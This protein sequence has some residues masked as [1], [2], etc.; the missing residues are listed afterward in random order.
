MAKTAEI[1]SSI[2]RPRIA[3]QWLRHYRR[4]FE[5]RDNLLGRSAY[6]LEAPSNAKLDDLS[7]AGA[8]ES[9]RAISLLSAGATK[10]RISD[11]LEA[12]LRIERGGYGICELTGEEIETERLQA[13][14]WTR[15]SLKGQMQMEHAGLGSR[16]MLTPVE[17][18]ADSESPDDQDSD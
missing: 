11:V 8:E 6:K 9:E 2:K 4:L 3:E 18:I 12:I 16:H 14:P 17:S 10:E 7:D 13:M 5:E 1:L 15:Y